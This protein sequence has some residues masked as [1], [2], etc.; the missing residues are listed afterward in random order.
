ML[1]FALV[2]DASAARRAR[3]ALA[4][5]GA[6]SGVVVGTLPEL[7][8][9]TLDAY[10]L[11][12]PDE[13]REE[14]L[15]VEIGKAREA[16][17]RESFDVAPEETVASVRAAL[18]DLVSSTDPCGSLP[19]DRFQHL[20]D[21][22]RRV[23]RDLFRL[24]ESLD[25]RLPGHLASM[26][27]L[28]RAGSTSVI[29]PISVYRPAIFTKAF[30]T[31]WELELISGIN[32]CATGADGT[33]DEDLRKSLECGLG[34]S[35][36]AAPGTA[37]RT[38]QDRLFAPQTIETPADETVQWV[39]VRD[40]YQEAEI[41]AGMAQTLLDGN[42]DLAPSDIGVLLP[43][44]SCYP[45]AVG[46]AFHLAGLALAGLPGERRR[47]D[48]GREA[49]F[50]FLF[51]RQDPAP[52]MA[53]AACLAS[54]LM[55]WPPEEGASMAQRVMDGRGDLQ[56]PSGAGPE[57]REMLELLQGSDTE[58]SSL[59]SS[60][61][62]FV[63]LL[64]GGNGLATHKR[65][66]V[67]S[68]DLICEALSGDSEIDWARLRRAAS[69][70]FI[71]NGDSPSYSVEGVTV[72]REGH[73]PWRGARHLFVLG[74]SQGRYPASPRDSAVFSAG[75]IDDIRRC[76]HIS[77][78]RP[79]SEQAFLRERFRRQLLAVSDSVTFLVPRRTASGD[80]QHPSESL[81]FMRRMFSP[82]G[83][84]GDLVA[85]LESP[86]DRRRIRHLAMAP[87]RR[88]TPPRELRLEDPKLGRNL[89]AIRTD[90]EGRPKPESPSGLAT[91]L[92]SPLAWLLQRAGAEPRPW[93]PES[94]DPRVLGTLAHSVF[95]QLFRPGAALPERDGIESR[96]S[97]LLDKAARRRAPFMRGPE[98]RVERHHLAALATKAAGEWREVLDGLGAKILGSEVWL[99]GKWS[100]VGVHGQADLILGVG[101]DRL[102]VVDYKWSAS[103]GHR[104]RMELGYDVQAS[105]Y[106]AMARTGG[107]KGQP[108]DPAARALAERL[109]GAA[110]IGIVYFTMRDGACLADAPPPGRTHLPG[111]ETT[112]ED[113]ARQARGI[114]AERLADFD[115][116]IVRLNSATDRAEFEK[117]GIRPYALDSSPIVGLFTRPESPAGGDR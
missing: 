46:D 63:A 95:E 87:D 100:G 2:P 19:S 64:E 104:T 21:R 47:R 92:V 107:A 72:L 112:E 50:H 5:A 98:W 51:C 17:W 40:F 27:K 96:V 82:P 94:A 55:P 34:C 10:C 86:A 42:P 88:P 90:P 115:A 57:P 1:H 108:G 26:H 11:P 32:A 6:R 65:R 43:D 76:L 114:L 44:D 15:A 7:L 28:L 58:P 49:V 69:P 53:L 83:R 14:L 117:A 45:A 48:L 102:L 111:W 70:E 38:M 113:P 54:A 33:F 56:A 22:L 39:G 25:G 8:A 77:P 74:F 80:P 37:L 84:A 61:R 85:E 18:I 81:A 110:K 71:A 3:R 105:L 24:A 35:D 66:G 62:R 101:A 99:E 52:A 116:G 9:R 109:A 97:R 41:A 36:R 89:L 29:Q 78:L 30:I 73:E 59:A 60:V 75:D 31:K 79:A 16:F 23:V 91:S 106:R 4:A 103:T 12:Q 13:G 67:E 68:A 93:A 20:P